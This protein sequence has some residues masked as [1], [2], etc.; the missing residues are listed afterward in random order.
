ME[1]QLQY[2][3]DSQGKQEAVIV[4]IEQWQAFLQDYQRLLQ[5]ER[6]KKGIKEAFREV[7]AIRSGKQ[8]SVSLKEFLDEC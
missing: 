1:I 5:Y 2:I 4:P 8:K 6:L 7:K 3:H